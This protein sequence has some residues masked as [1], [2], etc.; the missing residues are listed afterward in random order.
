MRDELKQHMR[1][2]LTL[3]RLKKGSKFIKSAGRSIQSIQPIKRNYPIRIVGPRAR[4]VDA[5]NNFQ[6]G[7]SICQRWRS[8]CAKRNRC[9]S[10]DIYFVVDIVSGLSSG[11]DCNRVSNIVSSFQRNVCCLFRPFH[12]SIRS[13]VS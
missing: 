8:L 2:R 12:W 13:P 9:F 11:I 10:Y 6:H 1:W 3:S 7:V 5:S 4:R